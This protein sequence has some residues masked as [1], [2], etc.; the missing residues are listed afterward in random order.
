MAARLTGKYTV[1]VLWDKQT[2]S[3]VNNESADI[4]RMFNSAFDGV[5]KHPEVDLYPE[6][7]KQEI[8]YVNEWIY[9]TINN[10]VYRTGFATKQEPY[11]EAFK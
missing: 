10:G 2:K 7:L 3:I 4:V 9:P 6:H 5:A 11:E 1:P 8:D